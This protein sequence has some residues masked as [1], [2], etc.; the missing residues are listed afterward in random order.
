MQVTIP[1]VVDGREIARVVANVL[2]DHKAR[3]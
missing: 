1:L 2:S 3:R